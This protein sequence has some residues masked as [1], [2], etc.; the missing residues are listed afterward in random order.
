[1][2]VALHSFVCDRR[3]AC[4]LGNRTHASRA[5][6]SA[7]SLILGLKTKRKEG[8]HLAVAVAKLPLTLVYG[9]GVVK[10]EPSESVLP[11]VL[12]L[13]LV[14]RQ[15]LGPVEHPR[16]L[17][18]V[19]RKRALVSV[20][21]AVPIGDKRAPLRRYRSPLGVPSTTTLHT[22]RAQGVAHA[23]RAGAALVCGCKN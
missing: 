11:P 6:L 8:T 3:T 22:R 16:A 10:L 18:V 19:P 17:D 13:P 23:A 2:R 12:H 20:A 7:S 21:N 14:R 4:G 15:L 5:S 1:M 9:R